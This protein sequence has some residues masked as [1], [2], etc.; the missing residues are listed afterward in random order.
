MDGI[1]A[2]LD[3]LGPTVLDSLWRFG[4]GVLI[5]LIVWIVARLIRGTVRSI[6]RRTNLDNRFELVRQ[7][8]VQF[9]GC[10][11]WSSRYA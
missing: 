4:G 9:L 1:S 8:L 11:T 6:M 5:L 3:N 2:M 7:N 10:L